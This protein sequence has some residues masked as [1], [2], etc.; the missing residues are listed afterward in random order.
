MD[1][2]IAPL[3]A[4]VGTAPDQTVLKAAYNVYLKS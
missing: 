3:V 2:F 4:H 1:Q